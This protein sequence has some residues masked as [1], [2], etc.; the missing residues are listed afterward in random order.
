MSGLL[1]VYTGPI[2][3]ASMSINHVQMGLDARAYCGTVE[4]ETTIVRKT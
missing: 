2:M 3:V 1:H 4:A